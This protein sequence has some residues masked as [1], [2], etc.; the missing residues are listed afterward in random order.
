MSASANDEKLSTP[1]TEST[2]LTVE[3]D[4]CHTIASLAGEMMGMKLVGQGKNGW[5]PVKREFFAY[6]PDS[7][8]T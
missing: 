2:L 4:R 1:R 3:D 7:M 6:W 5:C 8:T